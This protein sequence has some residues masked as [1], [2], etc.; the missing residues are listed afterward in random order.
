VLH[1]FPG[2]APLLAL[3]F[4]WLGNVSPIA[5]QN[6]DTILVGQR[7][8]IT[9]LGSEGSVVESEVRSLVGTTLT[10]ESGTSQ[11]SYDLRDLFRLQ[12][13][14]GTSGHTKIGALVGLLTGGVVLGIAAATG[15]CSGDV[16]G[17]VETGPGLAFGAATTLGGALVGAL[18]RTERWRDVDPEGFAVVQPGVRS[19]WGR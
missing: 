17:G 18:I 12:A 13:F 8:R 9:V 5:A 3:G 19:G 6:P 7:L 1:R 4:A 2:I 10:V 11:T 14:E 15:E 16:C